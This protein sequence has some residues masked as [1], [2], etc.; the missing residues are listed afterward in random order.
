MDKLKFIMSEFWSFL[1]PFIKV[2]LSDVG[3]VLA[4]AAM[5]AVQ[6]AARGDFN[7]D[8]RRQ[9]AFRQIT[10]ELQRRGLEVATS[11]VNAAIEA[12]VL[13]LKAQQ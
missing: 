4:S 7:S 13:K 11:T 8:E 12:A 3:K 6:A 9:I 1:L 10:A 5:N 2:L